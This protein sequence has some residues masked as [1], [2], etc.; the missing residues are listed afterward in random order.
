MISNLNFIHSIFIKNNSKCFIKHMI[1]V[2]FKSIVPNLKLA[3]LEWF[4]MIYLSHLI[5]PFIPSNDIKQSL[6]L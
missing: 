6:K 5:F 4:E 1:S 3:F 2:F